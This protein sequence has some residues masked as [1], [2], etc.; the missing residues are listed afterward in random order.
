MLELRQGHNL[1]T[2]L[3]VA[4]LSRS[5]FYYHIKVLQAGDPQAELKARIR[6]IYQQHKGRYGY[7]R[8]TAVLRHAGERINHKTVQRL[9]QVLG[10]KSLVRPKKYRSYRGQQASV[11]NL[12]ARHFQADRPNQKWVTDVTELN[13]RGE[14]LYLSPVMDLFNGE[15]VSYAM[16]R[17]PK[18][19]LVSIMLKKAM[20]K[21][22]STEAP[23]LHSD[24]GWQYQMSAYRRQLADRQLIQS[25][26][27]KGNCLDNAA[28]E[29]FFGT[30]KSEFF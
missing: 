1:A 29:S 21:L 23:M 30:L 27:R 10:L 5:T 3:E 20:S 16:H 8:I 9:M 24:Q 12:L 4:K 15:I 11:P 17:R 25:M 6:S 28:M 13:V 18:F 14:K 2:L 7:R 19:S 26:S 22:R